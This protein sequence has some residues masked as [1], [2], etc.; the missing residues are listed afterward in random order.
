MIGEEKNNNLF[1]TNNNNNNNSNDDDEM[2]LVLRFIFQD[3]EIGFV[4]SFSTCL[5]V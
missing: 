3:K 5:Y 2:G 1:Y 4:W